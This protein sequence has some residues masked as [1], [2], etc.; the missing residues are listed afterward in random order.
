MNAV[1]P[2]ERVRG[3]KGVAMRARRL[4]LH[5]FCAECAKVGIQR[6]TAIIDHPKPLGL[7]GLD[8]DENTQGLCAWHDAV[9][10]AAEA[11]ESR[12]ADN[13]PDWLR[14]A[15]VPLEI[16]CGPP[17]AG[18]TFYV[19]KRAKPGDY[20]IDL[21]A[22]GEVLSAGF[23]RS[24]T[25]PLLDRAIRMRNV[26]LGTLSD[27]TTGR[28]WFIVSAPTAA[29][30][31]WWQGVLGGKVVLINPGEAICLDRAVGR[32]SWKRGSEHV[33][34]WFQASRLGWHLER[35]RLPKQAFDAEGYPIPPGAWE[36]E[37][38]R[39]ALHVTPGSD[40]V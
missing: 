31:E 19:E 10:T 12:A 30:R 32:S 24:W 22:I 26:M 37:S 7:G 38:I 13:H 20:V 33:R 16:V 39:H 15:G 9:K 8:V 40:T 2:G 35:R 18:K 29:E 25:G 14:P 3:R 6:L 11:V 21:D 34:A 28:A 23:E 36:G 1:A 17:C 27:L 5:P 4:K